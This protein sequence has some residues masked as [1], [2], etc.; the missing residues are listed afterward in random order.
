MQGGSDQRPLH[1]R[2]IRGCMRTAF[3]LAAVPARASTSGW[4]D[5]WGKPGH[6]VISRI[7]EVRLERGGVRLA[8]YLNQLFVRRRTRGSATGTWPRRWRFSVS[9]AR[10]RH[11]GAPS[12]ST[13]CRWPGCGRRRALPPDR[14]EAG[15]LR[16]TDVPIPRGGGS[17]PRALSGDGCGGGQNRE[18]RYWRPRRAVRRTDATLLFAVGSGVGWIRRYRTSAGPRWWPSSCPRDERRGRR[19]GPA[20]PMRLPA[21]VGASMPPRSLSAREARC[22]G[23][24]V[25]RMRI[26]G[27]R[28][29]R[30]IRT[31]SHTW[32]M[33]SADRG[34]IPISLPPPSGT[35]PR[36]P[37]LQTAPLPWASFSLAMPLK[38][39]DVRVGDLIQGPQGDRDERRVLAD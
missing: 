4:A 19:P 33:T 14:R 13:R 36:E 28:A 21:R 22:G 17:C 16:T 25:R 1:C 9:T 27:W 26:V 30:P 7:A 6:R 37:N 31:G 32:V 38:P 2:G 12:A 34:A 15:Q 18:G 11:D 24:T 23:T 35:T 10:T 8:A 39:V 29:T 3:V 20:M 5:A